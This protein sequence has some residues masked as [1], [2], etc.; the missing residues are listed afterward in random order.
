MLLDY[1]IA[2]H[3]L[4][5]DRSNSPSTPAPYSTLEP[6]NAYESRPALVLLHG[7]TGNRESFGHLC[8]RL[9]ASR[10]LVRLDLPGHAMA[11]LPPPGSAGWHATLVA[12]GEVL[13]A[14]SP[15]GNPIDLLGYSQGG[16]LALALAL[17]RPDRVRRLILESASPGLRDAAERTARRLADERLAQM[18]ERDGLESFVSQWEQQPLFAS[19]SR[20]GEPAR[21]ALGL[22]RRS[23]SAA[24]LAAALRGLGV[25]VQPS[26]WDDL[27]RLAMP[28]LLVTG[29]NDAKFT[30]IA[31]AIVRLMPQAEHAVIRG[32]GHTPNLEEPARYTNLVI[33]FLETT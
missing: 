23:H 29:A 3:G 5:P 4:R 24:G 33:Q 31:Q 7:F 11:P 16:R 2:G 12:L 15:T 1:E 22:R 13:D 32:C 6:R 9:Q 26:Y 18:L 14:V 17:A 21:R 19:L 20:L 27:E 30:P 10:A 28:V 8:P 25:G